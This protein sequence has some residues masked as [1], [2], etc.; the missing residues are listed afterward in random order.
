M[1]NYSK[2][3]ENSR[4]WLANYIKVNHLQSCVLGISGGI[5]ST[6]SACL[7]SRVCKEVYQLF[8]IMT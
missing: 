7:A 6:I 1:I 2:F 3:I 8:L 4:K 5:D